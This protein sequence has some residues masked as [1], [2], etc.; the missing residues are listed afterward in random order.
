MSE[1]I[2]QMFVVMVSESGKTNISELTEAGKNMAFA[3]DY[4]PPVDVWTEWKEIEAKDIP[5]MV[6]SAAP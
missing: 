3:E 5:E 2:K 4:V 6:L 1:E